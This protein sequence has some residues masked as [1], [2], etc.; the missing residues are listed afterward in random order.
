[1]MV[2]KGNMKGFNTDQKAAVVLFVILFI[3]VFGMFCGNYDLSVTQLRHY[4]GGLYE[5]LGLVFS[6]WFFSLCAVLFLL[7]GTGGVLNE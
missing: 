6:V 5:L 4:Q 1:M 2:Y 7:R 3:P